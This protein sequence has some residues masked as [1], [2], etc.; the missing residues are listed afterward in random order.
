MKALIKP[1]LNP[2]ETFQD[3]LAYERTNLLLFSLIYYFVSV[4]MFIIAF[5]IFSDKLFVISRSPF[6]LIYFTNVAGFFA[7][8][9]LS[10]IF[11]FKI[12]DIKTYQELKTFKKKFYVG[13]YLLSGVPFMGFIAWAIVYADLRFAFE[14]I[15]AFVATAGALYFGDWKSFESHSF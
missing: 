8:A 6:G 5:V 9:T 2:I 12:N 11:L 13:F 3:L 7:A 14:M 4:F 1:Y 15:L 10:Q